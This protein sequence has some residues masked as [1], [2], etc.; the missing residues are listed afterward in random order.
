MFAVQQPDMADS[1]TVPN[2]DNQVFFMGAISEK[3]V[4]VGS[5]AI[6]GLHPTKTAVEAMFV[7]HKRPID[8]FKILLIFIER[9][10]RL[11]GLRFLRHRRWGRRRA[12]L[13]HEYLLACQESFHHICELINCQKVKANYLR[14]AKDGSHV[15]LR[16]IFA[17][18]FFNRNISTNG[19][20]GQALWSAGLLTKRRVPNAD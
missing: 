4:A 2:G 13:R 3:E 10:E 9:I 15:V 8:V 12:I 14:T 19:F 11:L 18:H 16:S 17:S 20:H 7:F 1:A 6:L 5:E